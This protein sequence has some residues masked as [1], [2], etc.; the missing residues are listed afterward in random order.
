MYDD[1]MEVDNEWIN[2]LKIVTLR[3]VLDHRI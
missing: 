3:I 2:E 1:E